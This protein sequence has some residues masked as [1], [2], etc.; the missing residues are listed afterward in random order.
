MAKAPARRLTAPAVDPLDIARQLDGMRGMEDGWADGMQHAS[1]WGEGYGKAPSAEGLAWLAEQFKANYPADL[2]RPYLCPTPEGL[3]QAEWTLAAYEV[4]LA[5]DLIARSAEWH[6][7]DHYTGQS[8]KRR[9]D[10]NKKAAWKRLDAE[11]RRLGSDHESLKG[12]NEAIARGERP[13]RRFTSQAS[14]R[15]FFEY[16][17]WAAGPGLEPDWSE[18]LRILQESQLKGIVNP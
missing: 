5:I 8:D 3:V 18:S 17:S 7:L 1:R 16:T 12:L 6:C 11:V 4:S 2:P 9:L 10:L 14:L 13:A 15:K